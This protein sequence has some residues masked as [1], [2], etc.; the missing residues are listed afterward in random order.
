MD[1]LF[2]DTTNYFTFIASTN[3]R[4]SLPQRGKNKQRRIDLRQ[5]SLALL[6]SRDGHIPLFSHT[7]EGNKV[8]VTEF[9]DSFTQI[10]KR[11]HNF[12]SDPDKITLV[13]DKGNHSLDNQQKVDLSGFGYI[14]SLPCCYHSD[15]QSIPV[16]TYDKLICHGDLN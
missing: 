6:V 15:L 12:V 5:F 9:S 13:Y 2:Y 16:H 4:C 7:Y 14:T 11:I 10:R 3:T 8:D 1:T